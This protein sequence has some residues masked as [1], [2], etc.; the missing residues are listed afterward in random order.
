MRGKSKN[1]YRK[2]EWTVLLG[3]F[4]MVGYGLVDEV[5]GYLD[6][7]STFVMNLQRLMFILLSII[8]ANDVK[9]GLKKAKTYHSSEQQSHEQGP[10]DQEEDDE[11]TDDFIQRSLQPH[12][13][14]GA[15]KKGGQRQGEGGIIGKWQNRLISTTLKEVRHAHGETC[16]LITW[17]KS[18]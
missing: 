8:S 17:E 14:L 2:P 6:D 12:N 11:D 5:T 3:P 4:W 10:C 7:V 1:K 13:H 16:V 9:S 15:Q 18:F